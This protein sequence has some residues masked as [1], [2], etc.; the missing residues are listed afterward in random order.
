MRCVAIRFTFADFPT[1]PPTLPFTISLA[2][3]LISPVFTRSAVDVYAICHTLFADVRLYFTSAPPVP[4]L[5]YR[6]SPATTTT[7]THEFLCRSTFTVFLALRSLRVPL[8]FVGRLR[9]ELRVP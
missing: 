5:R 7:Y 1:L 9:C 3:T 2:F 8:P 6:T 4:F